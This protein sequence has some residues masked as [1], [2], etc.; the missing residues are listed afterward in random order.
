M[1]MPTL[2]P[3]TGRIIG[4]H[5]SINASVPPHANRASASRSG[6]VRFHD[7]ASDTNR[8]RILR[9]NIIGSIQTFCQSTVPDFA[10]AGAAV[11][12][13]SLVEKFREVIMQDEFLLRL[14][15]V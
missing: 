15:P 6:T 2:M 1:Q 8:I 3:A 12:P 13:V 11:R 7:F 10:A 4:T 5:A 14:P 9:R